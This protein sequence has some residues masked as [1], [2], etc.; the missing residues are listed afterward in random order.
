MA[1]AGSKLGSEKI[2]ETGLTRERQQ[3]FV[4]LRELG[5]KA[6]IAGP[7]GVAGFLGTETDHCEVCLGR[8]GY[9]GELF[10][11]VGNL[12]GAD[13]P[14]AFLDRKH[15]AQ[16]AMI[17]CVWLAEINIWHDVILWKSGANENST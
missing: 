8:I 4:D 12:L 3:R 15:S 13:Y 9:C 5:I 10:T 11:H 1:S 14:L 2:P 17:S 6:V 16:H 7:P